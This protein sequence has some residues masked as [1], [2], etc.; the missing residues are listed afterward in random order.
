MGDRGQYNR[1]SDFLDDIRRVFINCRTYNG[2]DSDYFDLTNRLE[3]SF[4]GNL[5]ENSGGTTGYGNMK[6][7]IKLKTQEMASVASSEMVELI[8]PRSNT[9]GARKRKFDE[10]S[11]ASDEIK[12]KKK[13]DKKNKE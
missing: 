2:I 6:E 5:L 10:N 9:I 1:V 4:C 11:V 8:E 13:K 3:S 7:F 12:K